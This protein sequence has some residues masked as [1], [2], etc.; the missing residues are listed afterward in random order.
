[1]HVYGHT[2]I[3]YDLEVE[4]VRYIQW[5]L[6]QCPRRSR[7][8]TKVFPSGPRVRIYNHTKR[9]ELETFN[10]KRAG[11]RFSAVNCRVRLTQD[12]ERKK[13]LFVCDGKGDNNCDFCTTQFVFWNCVAGWHAHPKPC[14]SIRHRRREC[15]TELTRSGD[16]Q[17]HA[18]R[19]GRHNMCDKNV[20]L[21]PPNCHASVPI[22]FCPMIPSCLLVCRDLF[23]Q[24]ARR[25][26]RGNA[27]GCTRKVR[28]FCIRTTDGRVGCR[29]RSLHFGA[30]TIANSR[31]TFERCDT[32]PRKRMLIDGNIFVFLF[33]RRVKMSP[34]KTDKRWTV[35]YRCSC[36][37]PT[38]LAE[39]VVRV[40]LS[41]RAG[42]V[43]RAPT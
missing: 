41:A 27:E 38:T 42:L 40:R 7:L 4:G 28:S 9:D 2:H 20:G 11:L 26:S 15:A 13:N 21:S 29:R 19:V 39:C 12:S 16:R 25:S 36:P 32:S 33:T 23:V 6:G 31:G 35:A 8:S 34:M 17:D 24:G 37:P 43:P 14:Y 18:P 10:L 5:P 30:T 22:V 3:P 1:M